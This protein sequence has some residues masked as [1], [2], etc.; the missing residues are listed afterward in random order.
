MVSER[1][2][3]TLDLEPL[4]LGAHCL[5]IW[6]PRMFHGA[7]LAPDL[8]SESIVL[9]GVGVGAGVGK[10]CPTLTPAWSRRLTPGSRR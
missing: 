9:A 4:A 6:N 5:L 10:I 2:P 1:A 8:E 3:L 7:P